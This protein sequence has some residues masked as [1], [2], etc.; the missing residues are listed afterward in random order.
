MASVRMSNQLRTELMTSV[1]E[2][3]KLADPEPTAKPELAT[4]VLDALREHP[5]YKL[6]VE[7]LQNK[8]VE[9]IYNANHS[10]SLK[11]FITNFRRTEV[12]KRIRIEGFVFQGKQQPF[13]I[14]LPIPGT[15]H[16]ADSY[17]GSMTVH[18]MDFA[19]SERQAL[20]ATLTQAAQDLLDWKLRFEN[21]TKAAKTLIDNCNTVGQFLDAWP[22][23]ESLLKKE[24]IQKLNEKTKSARDLEAAQ[25]RA[26][27]DASL[28]SPTLLV[29]EI[30]GAAGN[31]GSQ[32]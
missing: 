21:Y 4:I 15:M 24:I 30:V 26:Q 23:A 25:A 27:F 32:T 16:F 22:E 3:F 9:D 11:T 29:A 18:M 13:D 1:E 7:F 17:H 20:N 10:S 6:A 2:K 5:A 19:P 31:N 28:A 14:M 8:A 12:V